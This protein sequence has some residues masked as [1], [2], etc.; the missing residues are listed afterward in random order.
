MLIP[1]CLQ[2]VEELK[3]GCVSAKLGEISMLVKRENSMLL[4]GRR[5]SLDYESFPQLTKYLHKHD[6]PHV[7]NLVRSSRRDRN[8]S[9]PFPSIRGIVLGPHSNKAITGFGGGPVLSA[10]VLES[11][12]AAG[13][14]P[15]VRRAC[16][17]TCSVS[18][19]SQSL[20]GMFVRSN[21]CENRQSR[22]G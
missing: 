15:D 19:R 20:M 12:G 10:F 9:F 21:D 16:Q 1:G 14:M 5:N 2:S 18:G 6:R 4:E 17:S 8:E 13:G 7:L 22:R 3:I 11:G